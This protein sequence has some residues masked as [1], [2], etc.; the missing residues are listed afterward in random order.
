MSTDN[1]KIG[2]LI[3]IRLSSERLPKK[4]LKVIK[5]KPV[6][7]HLL[8]RAFAS[9]HLERENVIVCTTT[10]KSDDA[11]ASIVEGTGARI[12][13][14][15]TN[16]IIDR[17]W[18]AIKHYD[19]DAVIEIDG[20]DI[21]ADTLYMDYCL[22]E[23]INDDSLDL[24]ICNNLPL[25]LGTK[26]IRKSA[27][28]KILDI[29]KTEHNDT[30]FMYFF[31]KTGYCKVKWLEPFDK[32]HIHKTVRFTLDYIEDFQFFEA[33]FD[34]LYEENKI[35]GIDDIVNILVQKPELID[36]NS[37]LNEEYMVRTKELMKLKY[38]DKNGNLKELEI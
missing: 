12:Y 24:V 3:P 19:F 16:D 27:F 37:F 1:M 2:A 21:C 35:F 32:N 5:G 33:V 25:G 9:K 22:D 36:I 26:A 10:E 34:A 6:V 17:F 29:Y 28:E 15:S 7:Q 13:R 14:G 8:E 30:G 38:K 23:L 4:A 18:N 20:D 31:T 11:L